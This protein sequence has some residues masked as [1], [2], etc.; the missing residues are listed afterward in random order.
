M[1]VG[2]SMSLAAGALLLAAA[3][4]RLSA[5][6]NAA[7]PAAKPAPPIAAMSALAFSPTGTLFVGDAISGAVFALD[8]G[9]R[10]KPAEVK[11]LAIADVETRVAALV[12]TRADDVVIHDLAVDPVSYDI[13]LAISRNRGKWRN[14][15]TLP[16][17]LGN[18]TELVKI[19]SDGNFHGVELEGVPFT[20]ADLPKPVAAGR[21]H[22][23]KEGVDTRSEAITDLAWDN[24]TIWVAGLSNEEFSS[25]IWRLPY[26]FPASAAGITTVENYHIGHQKWETAAPVRTLVPHKIGGKDSLIAA[27]L[28]TPL[29]IYPTDSLKDGQ[30]VRGRTVSEL[31]S[32]NYPLDMVVVPGKDGADRLLIAN[33]A[34]PML[35][36]KISDIDSF[37]GEIKEPIATYTGGVKG[38]YRPAGAVQQLDLIGTKHLVMLQRQPS[39]ALALET[40]QLA[41]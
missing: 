18:A 28:C 26:P 34:L 4:P 30:H 39:G 2:L 29:V 15:W 13:Y 36:V 3:A 24:G 14:K 38:D 17:D 12:G 21:K 23:W 7:A 32:G 10:S 40:W 19:G 25:A 33:S 41:P 9:S 37:E 6:E 35:S 27:Y 8:L 16:N 20:R 11:I 31:G 22:E 5:Q 1:K